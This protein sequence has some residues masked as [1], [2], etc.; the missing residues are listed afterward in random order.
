M[1]NNG[2]RIM[3]VEPWSPL[4]K[5]GNGFTEVVVADLGLTDWKIS[6]EK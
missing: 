1:Q 6:P 3:A 2:G 5:A 4:I